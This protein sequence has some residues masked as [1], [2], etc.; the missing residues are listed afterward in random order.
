[1]TLNSLKIIHTNSYEGGNVKSLGD[2]TFSG[3]VW[4]T[5]GIAI[6]T[7]CS[8]TFCLIM[9]L[10]NMVFAGLLENSAKQGGI[11]MG[12]TLLNAFGLSLASGLNSGLETLVS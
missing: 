5:L 10:V 7:I 9:Q 3:K 8:M 11:G 6:P 4:V 12:N 1:M 2:D